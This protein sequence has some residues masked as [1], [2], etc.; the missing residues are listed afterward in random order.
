MTSLCEVG[1]H[2]SWSSV[3]RT[4]LSGTEIPDLLVGYYRYRYCS[5]R[6]V[7]GTHKAMSIPADCA[8]PVLGAIKTD[9]PGQWIDCRS[10]LNHCC[11]TSSTGSNGT[12]PMHRFTRRKNHGVA[13]VDF[14]SPRLPSETTR[15]TGY[16]HS[17]GRREERA[18]LYTLAHPRTKSPRKK[19]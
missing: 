19:N 12:C 8:E 5:T 6:Y 3:P 18:I 15:I 14:E 17:L 11:T 1:W 7:A 10:R 4:R 13:G 16:V 2:A 9:F